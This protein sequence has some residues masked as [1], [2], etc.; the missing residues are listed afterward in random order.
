MS[1]R[2]FAYGTLLVPAVV[3]ALLGRVPECLEATLWGYARGQVAG[4]AFPGIVEAG[5]AGVVGLC[6]SGISAQELEIL[7][8]FEGDLYVR[9]VVRVEGIDG[10]VSPAFAYVIRDRAAHLVQRDHEWELD[11]FIAAFS[12]EYVRRCAAL[13]RMY[14]AVS[15][16]GDDGPSCDDAG[17]LSTR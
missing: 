2:L 9:R 13:R 7:D 4:Q 14:D 16:A 1:N 11:Q 3:H 5:E 10:S 17:S 15:S 8:T 12:A 6:Y